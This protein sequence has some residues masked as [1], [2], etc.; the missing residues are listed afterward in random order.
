MT[1]LPTADIMRRA[2][3]YD[4]ADDGTA[5][6]GILPIEWN[7]V[8]WPEVDWSDLRPARFVAQNETAAR[9]VVR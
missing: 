7:A 9:R 5:K 4:A 3:F 6:L 8:G 2:A 1:V